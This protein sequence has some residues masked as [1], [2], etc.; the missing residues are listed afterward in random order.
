MLI[1]VYKMNS[2]LFPSS[3]KDI[4]HPI[5]WIGAL[6]SFSEVVVRPVESEYEWWGWPISI[7]DFY[8][9]SGLFRGI[10]QEGRQA[11]CLARFQAALMI[12]EL[13]PATHSP[14]NK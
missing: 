8:L 6:S 3:G 2:D 7:N 9:S 14:G 1:K 4:S 12:N 10:D 13:D 11:T 5:P